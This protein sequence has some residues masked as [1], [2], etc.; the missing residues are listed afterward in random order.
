LREIM[1]QKD[2]RI[3]FLERELAEREKEMEKMREYEMPVAPET[4]NE[5]L[6]DLERRIQDL[7]TMER[8]GQDLG[9][10]ER[11]VRDLEA[12]VKG[13]MEEVLD[14]KTV[15]MRLSKERDEQRKVPPVTEGKKTE[16]TIKAEPRPGVEPRTP[17]R[18]VEVQ[19][20]SARPAP[21][22]SELELIMQNDG[23]LKPEIR[24]PSEYIVA[25]TRPGT[26]PVQG[27]RMGGRMAD[28]KAFVEQ[29]KRVIDDIIQAEDDT[30]DLDR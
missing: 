6:R 8:G 22:A 4:D 28:R 16:V 17:V 13:L 14:L 3:R 23:T 7:E 21:E 30:L 10:L 2:A 5:Y 27:R 9:A 29:K 26:L 20:Q 25:S 18:P 15:V 19:V 24:R 11:R 12:L 1:A